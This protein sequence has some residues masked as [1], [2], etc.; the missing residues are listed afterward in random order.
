MNRKIFFIGIFLLLLQFTIVFR[1]FSIYSTHPS[2]ITVFIILLTLKI[3]F[4]PALLF[5]IFLGTIQDIYMNTLFFYTTI[6]N[7]LIVLTVNSIRFLVDFSNFIYG[8]LLVFFLSVFEYF[9]KDILIFFKTGV[10]YIS[11]DCIVYALANCLI[12]LIF[13]FFIRV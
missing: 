8:F 5:S 9:I 3:H 6:T 1:G 7:V 4:R 2:F 13:R 10:F 12:Y 11:I